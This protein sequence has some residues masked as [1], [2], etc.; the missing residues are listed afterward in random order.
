MC[1]SYLLIYIYQLIYS[2]IYWSI[3]LFS[4]YLFINLFTHSCIYFLH[5]P[6]HSISQVVTLYLFIYFDSFDYIDWL[7]GL[8]VCC[9]QVEQYYQRALE[10]YT[11][12]LGPDDPNV[13][14]TKN[15]L[16]RTARQKKTAHNSTVHSVT[17]DLFH[18]RGSVTESSRKKPRSFVHLDRVPQSPIWLIPD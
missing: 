3:Y 1:L 18:R 2:H 8:F 11:T 5:S 12:R 16:V 6:L 10:I 9:L 17:T 13:A 14:K 15:N 4:T 7:L